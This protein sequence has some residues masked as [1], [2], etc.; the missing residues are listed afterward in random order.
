MARVGI[1]EKREIVRRYDEGGRLEKAE[2]AR[3]LGISLSWLRGKVSDFRAEVEVAD[4]VAE[5]GVADEADAG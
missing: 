5:E 3:E 2:L 4:A 1:E